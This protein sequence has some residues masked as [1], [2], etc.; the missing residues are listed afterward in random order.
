MLGNSLDKGITFSHLFFARKRLFEKVNLVLL[1]FL[2]FLLG[3][4]WIIKSTGSDETLL[5]FGRLS[6]VELVAKPTPLNKL[7]GDFF[8][9]R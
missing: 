4:V 9:K 7:W 6:G 5:V 3:Y 8:E 1:I 2:I